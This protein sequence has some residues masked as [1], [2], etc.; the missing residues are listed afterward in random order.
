MD[1]DNVHSDWPSAEAFS[2]VIP[3]SN[4]MLTWTYSIVV[5]MK[6]KRNFN[7]FTTLTL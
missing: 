5:D 2:D 1:V 4:G 6:E 3:K 7:L